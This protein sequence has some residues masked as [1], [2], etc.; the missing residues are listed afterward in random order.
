MSDL[1]TAGS[2]LVT[3]GLLP[4]LVGAVC[5]TLDQPSS[6]SDMIRFGWYG[7]RGLRDECG[8]LGVARSSLFLLP[9]SREA[10]EKPRIPPLGPPLQALRPSDFPLSTCIS[11]GFRQVQ[12]RVEV[13]IGSI[14]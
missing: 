13:L 1:S 11:V 14:R 10:C 12:C 3:T 6:V 4:Y 2:E 7:L 8:M 9:I 5:S